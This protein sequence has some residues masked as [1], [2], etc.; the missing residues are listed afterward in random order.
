MVQKHLKLSFGAHLATEAPPD[1][2]EAHASV[3][4][5]PKGVDEV[6]ASSQRRGEAHVSKEQA[7]DMP[8]QRRTP[9]RKGTAPL[10]SRNTETD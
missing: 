2:T 5:R 10:H 3:Q 4:R 9:L 1:C 7:Q 8:V 6:H